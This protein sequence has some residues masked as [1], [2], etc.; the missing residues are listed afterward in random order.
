MGRKQIISAV[1]VLS[2]LIGSALGIYSN[3][4]VPLAATSKCNHKW[5]EQTNRG[6]YEYK[7]HVGLYCRCNAGPFS[8]SER[9]KHVHDIKKHHGNDEVLYHSGY[10]TKGTYI[11]TLKWV[12]DT[13]YRCSICGEIKQDTDSSTAE[14]T[15]AEKKDNSK[16]DATIS[17]GSKV[18]V[19]NGRY[20]IT[21]AKNKTVQYLGLADKSSAKSVSIAKSVKI[22]GKSYKVTSIAAKAFKNNKKITKVTI[23]KNVTSIGK[24]AFRGCKNLKEV[25]ISTAKLTSKNVGSNAFKGISKKVKIKVPKSK[26]KAYKKLLKKKGITG[27]KQVIK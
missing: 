7:T 16:A 21:S 26:K 22:G 13:S 4:N 15:N 20:K 24:E 11:T 27:K 23:G 3:A 10:Y 5:V 8:Q 19:N 9:A 17:K 25:T 14:S 2:M 1:L 18:T 6:H 12:V